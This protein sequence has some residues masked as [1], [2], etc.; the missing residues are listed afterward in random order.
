L[1]DGACHPSRP[2]EVEAHPIVRWSAN[3]AIIDNLFRNHFPGEQL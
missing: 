1:S 2:A 3:R